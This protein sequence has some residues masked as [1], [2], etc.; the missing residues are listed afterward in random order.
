MGAALHLAHAHQT[1]PGPKRKRGGGGSSGDGYDKTVARIWQDKRM[2]SESRELLL[3]MVWLFLRDPARY[4][5]NGDWVNSWARADTILGR[6]GTGR[7]ERQRIAELVYADR[8]RYE[9]D[10]GVDEGCQAPMIRR[11][12]LCGSYGG[13]TAF[14]V[15]PTT[16]WRTVVRYC[17]RHEAWGR[18]LDAA[19]RDGTWQ[20]PIPNL[21]GLMPSYMRL[22]TGQD[23]WVRIY[24]DAARSLRR[25]WD[26][27]AVH[28][29]AADDWVVPGMERAPEPFRLRLAAVDGELLGGAQ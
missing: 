12:G 3:L 4:D 25:D 16:G 14:I 20:E 27:P 17:R 8:P 21:G 6:T 2:T 19:W 18:K 28:G 9:M 1:P 26:P 13:D 22:K 11:D 23:G 24:A 10:R 15:D 29:M 5:G 7:N